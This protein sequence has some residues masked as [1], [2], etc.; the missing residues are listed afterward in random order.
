MREAGICVTTFGLG[1]DFNEDVMQAVAKEGRGYFFYCRKAAQIPRFVEEALSQTQR[2]VG[3]HATLSLAGVGGSTL[4]KIYSHA[5]AVAHLHDLKQNNSITVACKLT[6]VP[7][8]GPSVPV[9]G[10]TL[11]YT[12]AA[13]GERK[14][15]RGVV[16]CPVTTD[17]AAAA[18]PGD[19]A[20]RACVL[21]VK[22]RGG[23]V[24][25]FVPFPEMFSK[26]FRRRCWSARW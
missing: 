9:L 22:V 5:D 8:E 18:Q 10:W 3:T 2:T 19:A 13:T 21:Q 26:I 7:G 12:D 14:E 1:K 25:E 6:A 11:A 4:R 23:V 20:A 24:L 15:K 17:A 16:D